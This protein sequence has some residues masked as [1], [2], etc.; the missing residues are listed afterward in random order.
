MKLWT[1][2]RIID[3]EALNIGVDDRV[4]EHGLGLF[5]TFR[6]WNGHPA[7]LSRHLNRLRDSAGVLGLPVHDLA[8]PSPS[9]VRDL[10]LANAI[11]LDARIRITLTGGIHRES[12]ARLWMRAASLSPSMPPATEASIDFGPWEVVESDP[13]ARHK[14]LNYWRRRLAHEFA[15]SHGLMEV[16]SHSAGERLWEG[17][18]TNLFVIKGTTLYTPSREGP[19]VPGIFR[20][21]V[22]EAARS[23][24][25]HVEEP[26]GLSM[27][28]FGPSSEVFLTNSVRE[29]IPV[30]RFRGWNWPHP[31]ASTRMIQATLNA[32]IEDA[33]RQRSDL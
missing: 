23:L 4:F 21:L 32:W 17:S 11:G 28:H 15:V 10:L 6:T 22:I 19:I 24:G 14:S 33:V 12:G 26:R 30:T 7:L 1:D 16:L 13:L 8:L 18:R 3:A 25:F 2:G 29:I 31:G 27:D 5:E 9:D 20:G